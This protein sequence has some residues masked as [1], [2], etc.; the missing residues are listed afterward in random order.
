M[1]KKF[2]KF[3][4]RSG[5]YC[6]FDKKDSDLLFN[7]YLEIPIENLRSYCST[8]LSYIPIAINFEFLKGELY[9]AI[10]S[11]TLKET[12]LQPINQYFAM[13][14]YFDSSL[15]IVIL[16]EFAHKI[17]FQA[18]SLS[19]KCKSISYQNIYERSRCF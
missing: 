5:M 15:R 17:G 16:R 9:K 12:D 6:V 7:C 13:C 10:V 2:S 4:Y 19:I 8:E 1:F 14:P 11:P 3:N 18:S